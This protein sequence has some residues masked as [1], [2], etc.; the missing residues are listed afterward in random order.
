V[1]YVRGKR[2]IE[3][4]IKSRRGSGQTSIYPALETAWKMLRSQKIARKHVILLSD[5]DS[6]PGDFEPLLERMQEAKTHGFDRDD[7]DAVAIPD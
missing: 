2:R 4:L 7:R 5:G 3:E 1:Q 6:A